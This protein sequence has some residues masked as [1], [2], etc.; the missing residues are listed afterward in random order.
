MKAL[1]IGANGQMGSDLMRRASATP[2]RPT[3]FPLTHAELD[4]TDEFAVRTTLETMRPEVVIDTAAYHRVDEVELNPERTLAANALAPFRLAQACAHISASLVFVSTDYVF[5]G[6]RSRRTPYGE[7]DT[8]AP[9][10]VYGASKL[11]GEALVRAALERHFIIRT[12]GLYGLSGATGRG[13]NF[14]E[15]MLALAAQGK[16][17]RVVNDQHLC[18]TFTLDLADAML[19]LITT[20][21]YGLHHITNDGACSWYEFTA[22]VPAVRAARRSLPDH[23]GGV[24]E[25]RR[26]AFSALA[27]PAWL[28]AGSSPLRHWGQALGDYLAPRRHQPARAA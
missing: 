14:V 18:P 5:G 1:V 7:G 16:P 25:R 6:D 21:Q 15:R 3:M 23:L 10:N 2:N 11:A 26:P 24:Q 27:H 28:A 8:P 19:D 20:E 22:R 4:V 9:L 13:G 17:I 12:S